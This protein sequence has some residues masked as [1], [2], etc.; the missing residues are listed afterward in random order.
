MNIISRKKYYSIYT[1]LAKAKSN[2]PIAEEEVIKSEFDQLSNLL[3]INLGKLGEEEEDF[4]ISYDWNVCRHHSL[5]IYSGCMYCPELIKMIHMSCLGTLKDWCVAVACESDE[6]EDGA[7]FCYR[8][9][10]FA[11]KNLELDY[12]IFI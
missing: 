1:E 7:F 10:T 4:M 6:F 5:G 3:Q 8:G 11:N 2:V 12:S 9:E